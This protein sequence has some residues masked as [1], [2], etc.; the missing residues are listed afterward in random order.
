MI[1]FISNA[2]IHESPHYQ[3]GTIDDVVDYCSTKKWLGVD[4]ETEGLD[5]TCDKMIMLQIGDSTNQYVIDTRDVSI[6]PL[7]DVLENT[8]IQKIFHN[9]KFDYKFIRRWA[10]IICE[11]IHDTFLTE[12]VLN[13]GRKIGFGLK[14]LVKRYYNEDLNKEVR[15]KFIGITT[16]PFTDEQII[17]GAKDIEY[18][19]RIKWEQMHQLTQNQLGPVANLENE[20]VLAFADI[21]YNGLDLDVDQWKSLETANTLKAD[22][23]LANLDQILLKMLD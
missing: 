7:R 13:C 8:K 22:V 23:L 5:F 1:Y 16:Q 11:N 20:A 18:L 2:A 19:N 9:A 17:Y 3:P 4:T 14:D 6:E 10:G 15:S 12:I 21:E